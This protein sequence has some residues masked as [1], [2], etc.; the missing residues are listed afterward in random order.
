MRDGAEVI[1]QGGV[2]VNTVYSSPTLFLLCYFILF[3]LFPCFRMVRT[4]KR[5][6]E[7]ALISEENSR[8]A[9]EAVL[10]KELS[11]R[12]AAAAYGLKPG[13]VFKRW[14]PS[15]PSRHLKF[16]YTK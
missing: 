8:K 1:S 4:Y 3:T 14:V 13:L 6:T 12:E 10:K 15:F 7:R 5:K 16:E 9:T 2:S 11:I